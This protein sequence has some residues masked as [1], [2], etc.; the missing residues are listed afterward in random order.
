MESETEGGLSVASRFLE[1]L[2]GQSSTLNVA[3]SGTVPSSGEYRLVVRRQPTLNPDRFRLEVVLPVGAS[4]V[5]RLPVGAQAN[6]RVVGWSGFLDADR[7]FTI[8]YEESGRQWWRMGI[9][10]IWQRLGL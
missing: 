7:V 3:T 4:P 6:G 9:A 8:R 10:A 1:V 5:G 2:P